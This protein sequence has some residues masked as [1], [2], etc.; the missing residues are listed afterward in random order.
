MNEI[1]LCETL[2]CLAQLCVIATK[3][4]YNAKDRRDIAKVRYDEN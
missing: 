3:K 1:I 4:S 2:H